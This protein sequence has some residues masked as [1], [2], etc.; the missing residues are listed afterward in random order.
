[1]LRE[2]QRKDG[3][4]AKGIFDQ[5]QPRSVLARRLNEAFAGCEK[6]TTAPPRQRR[7]DAPRPAPTTTN[8]SPISAQHQI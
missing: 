8:I 3:R 7:L 1:M 6:W 4:M 2:I 5:H